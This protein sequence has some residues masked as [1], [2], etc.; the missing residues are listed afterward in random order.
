MM[1]LITGLQ[2]RSATMGRN[3]IRVGWEIEWRSLLCM[4]LKLIWLVKEI[5]RTEIRKK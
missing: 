5:G 3:G 1:G 2:L 4:S